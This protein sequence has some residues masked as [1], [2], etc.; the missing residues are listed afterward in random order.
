MMLFWERFKAWRRGESCIASGPLRGRVFSSGVES[1]MVATGRPVA[2]AKGLPK[3]TISARVLR[4]GSDNW[5]NL[6]I[7]SQP[8]KEQ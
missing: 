8:G 6:G 7:I 3:G 2:L 1:E 5:E 4:A